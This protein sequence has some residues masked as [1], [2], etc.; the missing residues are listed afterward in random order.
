[1]RY[2]LQVLILF[3]TYLITA[4]LGLMMDAVSG[5]ATLVWP[6]TGIALAAL[7]IYGY[8]L[9]PGVALAAFLV[10]LWSGAPWPAAAGIAVGNTLEAVLGVYLLRCAGFEGALS[11]VKDV[12]GL[13]VLG[14]ILSTMV[15]A[16]VG[17]ASLEFSGAIP[18]SAVWPTWLAWWLGDMLG[19][20]VVAPLLLT[21][22]EWFHNRKHQVRSAEAALLVISTGAVGFGLFGGMFGAGAKNYPLSYV[23]F[24]PLIWAALRFGQVGAV[25]TVFLASVLAVWG[26]ARGIGPFAMEPLSESL[27]FLQI[28]MGV[29]AVTT[30]I[31]ASV[32]A[33]RRRAEGAIARQAEEA[34]RYESALLQ[35]AKT[36]H[37]D[38]ASAFRN[39]TEVDSKTM[40]VERVSVW[41]FN[42]DRSEIICENLYR[43]GPNTHEKGLRL[44]ARQYPR[45]FE[46]LEESR[47]ITAY[48]A[49]KDPRTSE[50]AEG[51]LKPNGITSMMDAPIR[52]H[53]KVAGVVCHEHVG[54]MR[55]WTVQEQDFAASIGEA[56]TLAHAGM[57]RRRAEEALARKAEELARS[58]KDLEEFAYV[59]SHDLRDPLQKIIGF[60]DLLKV[61]CAEAL[62]EKGHDYLN[63]MQNA[64]LRMN[65]LIDDILTFSRAA[66]AVENF[67]P[68]SL[69]EVIQEVLSNLE[70]M[71]LES[72][73]KISIGKFPVVHAD[74]S[75][76]RQLFQNLIGNALKFHK[77]EEPPRVVIAGRIV[78]GG[79][80][81]ISI[82]DNGIGFEEK[83]LERIFKPFERLHG[84]GEYH[85][86]G[87]GLAICQKIVERHRGRIIAKSGPGRGATFTVT[88]P[89]G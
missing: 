59:T 86:S 41:F 2:V 44:E 32:V 43:S 80:A 4:K 77:K 60:G 3:F 14:A 88:L 8:R 28:F 73:G 5:F 23:I 22:N 87:I 39:I 55:R 35:L 72:K 66:T 58:N 63:R 64:T 13:I 49:W 15:S 29:A 52:L 34:L 74:R 10:N 56:A 76:M 42:A 78:E 61:H 67:G 21:W 57:E 30:M 12:L 1:M 81:E 84:Q 51:Y 11:R 26:T 18:V 17:V 45:Y 38:L 54:P 68:V 46:A 25:S 50:F 48:D 40:N 47:H 27:S 71:I 20:I 70:V 19:N 69:Q 24:L 83:Y 62:G 37:P 79:T 31:L 53:G 33:E 36:E 75:Q 82:Q 65:Q 16:T 6:P 89:L 7:L 85:G 9:W